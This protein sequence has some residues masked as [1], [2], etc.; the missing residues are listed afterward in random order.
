MNKPAKA[1]KGAVF[2]EP[3]V[4][5]DIGSSDLYIPRYGIETDA[6]RRLVIYLGVGYKHGFFTRH[7]K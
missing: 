3:R 4:A 2:V 6:Y 1:G 5:V 7:K